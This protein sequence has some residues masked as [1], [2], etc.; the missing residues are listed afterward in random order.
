VIPGLYTGGEASGSGN[1]HGLA[2][3]HVTGFIAG[4]NV[5]QEAV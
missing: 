2:R 4:T 1:Q 3:A 5:V